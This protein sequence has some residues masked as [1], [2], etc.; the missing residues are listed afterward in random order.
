MTFNFTG[1]PLLVARPTTNY[2]QVENTKGKEFPLCLLLPYMD[3]FW[4]CDF[5]LPERAPIIEAK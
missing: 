3:F 5:E 4:A 1:T 2:G